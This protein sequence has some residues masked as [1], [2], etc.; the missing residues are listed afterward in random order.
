MPSLGMTN[1]PTFAAGWTQLWST[2]P[3]FVVALVT[4]VILHLWHSQGSRLE[5]SVVAFFPAGSCLLPAPLFSCTVGYG[6]L[7]HTSAVC[8]SGKESCRLS[9]INQGQPVFSLGAKATLGSGERGSALL[10]FDV[11]NWLPSPQLFNPISYSKVKKWQAGGNA[12]YS[13][14][15]PPYYVFDRHGLQLKAILDLLC[16]ISHPR[17]K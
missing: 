14:K 10:G 1:R 4:I 15:P 5:L 3:M 8:F 2:T 11:P 16:F 9:V 12:K 7:P 17:F 6:S 13:S